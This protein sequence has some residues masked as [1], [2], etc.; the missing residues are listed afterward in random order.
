MKEKRDV[1]RFSGA[2]DMAAGESI[3][4]LQRTE[5]DF[6]SD[7]TEP[8]DAQLLDRFLTACDEAAFA[9]L[10]RR[11]GP[12]VLGVCRRILRQPQDAED[13]FQATFLVLVRKAATIGRRELLGNWLYGVAY[14][15]ALDARAAT[16]RRR[17]HEKQVSPM[18]EPEVTAPN[19]VGAD[20]RLILDEELHRLPGKD[21][22]AVVLCDLEGQ[23]LRAAARRLA[24]PVGTLSGRLTAARALLARRLARRGLFFAGTGLAAVLAPGAGSASVPPALVAATVQAAAGSAP[25]PVAVL[26]QGVVKAMLIQKLKAVASALVAV[27]LVVGSAV[28]VLPAAPENRAEVLRLGARGRRVAWSPDGKTLAVVTKVEKAVLGFTY[29][30]SGSAIRLWD[31][32]TGAVR[33]TLAEDA[34]KGLAYQQVVFCA[35]GQTIAATVA[36][37][38]RQPGALVSRQVVKLWDARTLALKQTLGDDDVQLACVALSPDGKLV[39]AG[40]PGRKVVRLW[41]ATNGTLVRTLS[42]GSAQPWSLA[43][44]RDGKTLAVG[45]QNGDG[46]GELALWDVTTGNRIRTLARPRFVTAAAFAPDG[47][48]LAASD[49]GVVVVWD[50]GKGG[51]VVP[52][53]GSPGGC[54]GVAFAP[55]GRTVAAGGPDGQVRLWDA[56]TGV[57]KATLSG[58]TAEVYAVA[59]APNGR[60]LASASQDETVRLWPVGKP[61]SGAE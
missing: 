9:A 47:T 17:L 54:R 3:E 31:V 18:P 15:T 1:S 57:L 51:M 5:V 29:D 43:F 60:M 6:V 20:E 36:E 34:G 35:D 59:F 24:V 11:H 53:T 37:A 25:A 30:R 56:R 42:T 55:D 38:G 39:A 19:D 27:T 49:G 10:V 58:H 41:D 26:A 2:N 50:V 40:D 13:A 14:R 33:Q 45:G 7:A 8:T 48:R 61:L 21:R 4:V 44:S 32:A 28:L 23:T 16:A 12:M 22:V 52:L 46:T